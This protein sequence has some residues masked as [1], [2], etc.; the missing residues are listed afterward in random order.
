M[1][2]LFRGHIEELRLEKKS[3]IRA[4]RKRL[5]GKIQIS[6]EYFPKEAEGQSADLRP[7]HDRP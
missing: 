5:L 7:F 1:L 6:E 3:V 2:P 4:A